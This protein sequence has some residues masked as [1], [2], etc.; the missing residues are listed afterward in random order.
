[1][2]DTQDT[3]STTIGVAGDER[4][5]GEKCQRCGIRYLAVWA[6]PDA[7]WAEVTGQI[8]G[9]LRCMECFFLEAAEKSIHVEFWAEEWAK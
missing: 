3:A 7:L 2:P 8:G 9:G 1:M 5:Q 6:A 4:D